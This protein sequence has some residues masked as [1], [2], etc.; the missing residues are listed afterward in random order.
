MA[1]DAGHDLYFPAAD[2]VHPAH[3][4]YLPQLHRLAR[5]QLR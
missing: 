5:S 1:I 3:H 4:V 2:Q